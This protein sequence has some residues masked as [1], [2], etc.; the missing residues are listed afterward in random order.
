ME[1]LRSNVMCE[2]SQHRSSKFWNSGLNAW[3]WPVG[4]SCSWGPILGFVD[5]SLFVLEE[6]VLTSKG[7]LLAG[8]RSTVEGL[9]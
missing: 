5:F 9:E 7:E 2:F 8:K 1:V 6:L 3:A 4:G